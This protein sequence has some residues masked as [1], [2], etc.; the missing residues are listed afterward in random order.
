MSTVYLYIKQHSITGLKYF[1]KT[2]N[3]PYTYLG[4]GKYWLNHIRKHGKDYVKTLEVYSF[5]NQAECSEFAMRFS[6][7]NNIV[8]SKNWANL[9]PENGTSGGYRPN[10]HFKIY[11][12]S[13]KPKHT[14]ETKAKISATLKKPNKSWR[15]VT[16]DGNYFP[17]VAKALEHYNIR[18]GNLRYWLKTGKAVM[19]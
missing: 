8:E 18:D 19:V 16:I 1:G 3:D 5:E 9:A 7:E 11:N 2:T 6:E 15:P 10:N 13:G 12:V 17:S 14:A 4:S